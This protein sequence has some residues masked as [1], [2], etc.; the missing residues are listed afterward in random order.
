[1]NLQVQ[2]G[3]V[4]GGGGGEEEEREEESVRVDDVDERL[5]AK[6]PSFGRSKKFA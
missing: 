6:T 4:G 2:R 5:L 1:M 3:R